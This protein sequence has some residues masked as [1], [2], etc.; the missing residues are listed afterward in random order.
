MKKCLLALCLVLPS[1][2]QAALT[3]AFAERD[4]TP[5]LGMEVPGGY[6]KSFSK[7]IHDPCKAR[8]AVFDDGKTLLAL[9]G[10]D[11]LVVPRHLVLDA[12]AQIQQRCGIPADAVM[13]RP[14]HS[15]S[16][17]PVCMELNV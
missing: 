10:L 5:D 9:V 14:P 3:A 13:I 7:R 1:L 16:S 2:A 12:R 17:G 6:G 8:I 15:H 11:A 4:I